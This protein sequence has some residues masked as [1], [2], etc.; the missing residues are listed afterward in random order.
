MSSS[1]H[2]SNSCLG[3]VNLS[4]SSW[5]ISVLQLTYNIFSLMADLDSLHSNLNFVL[6]LSLSLSDIFGIIAAFTLSVGNIILGRQFPE[7]LLVWLSLTSLH[8]ILTLVQIIQQAFR[9][10][11]RLVAEVMTSEGVQFILTI[12]CM[13]LMLAY[14]Q[15]IR[16]RNNQD[17]AIK[18]KL[19]G[20]NTI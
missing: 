1:D 3:L 12:Y 20:Y 4:T 8:P 6:Y 16:Q 18:A 11:P 15:E 14:Y 7:Y 2:D 9:L 17:L 10:Q 5:L 19:R 13:Y